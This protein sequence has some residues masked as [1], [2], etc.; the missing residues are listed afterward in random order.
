M[1][2][3]SKFW[4]LSWFR[5]LAAGLTL[6]MPRFNPR[7]VHAGFGIQMSISFPHGSFIIHSPTTDTT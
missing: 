5:E 4:A 3:G 2:T 7:P 6:Q 1:Q